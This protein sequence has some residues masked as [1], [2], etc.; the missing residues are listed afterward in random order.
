MK[1]KSNNPFHLLKKKSP[2]IW[3]VVVFPIFVITTLLLVPLIYVYEIIADIPRI[4]RNLYQDVKST[5]K[6][7]NNE[8]KRRVPPVWK[9]LYKSF[10]LNK[11]IYCDNENKTY[12]NI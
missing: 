7:Q 9:N 8:L 6:V 1:N 11:D 3:A 5:F 12:G 4:G 10:V 2:R